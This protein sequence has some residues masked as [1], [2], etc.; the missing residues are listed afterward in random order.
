VQSDFIT[1][2]III[3]GIVNFLIALFTITIG[4]FYL[5]KQISVARNIEKEKRIIVIQ[6]L[7]FEL[8]YNKK[9]IEE[10]KEHSTVGDNLGKSG[11]SFSWEWNSPLFV[12]YSYLS[13]AC[14]TD[15]ALAQKL[16][17]IYSSLRSCEVII[18]QV[19]VLIAN[20]I[21]IKN[22][23]ING[24][25]L[26]RDEVIRLNRQ[27]WDISKEITDLFDDP[28]KELSILQCSLQE[29]KNE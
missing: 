23:V 5:R 2:N 14:Y 4:Y 18:K 11:N 16:T 27:L 3:P 22:Q 10:Y 19:H 15:T 6:A 7:I 17:F 1:L 8:N 21:Q 29:G 26:L 13:Q 25:N 28:I 12:N 24:R 20:N 9:L